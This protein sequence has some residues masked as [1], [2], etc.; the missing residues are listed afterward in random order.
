MTVLSGF[1]GDG[2]MTLLRLLATIEIPN[3]G[4]VWLDGAPASRGGTPWLLNPLTRN[5]VEIPIFQDPLG[6]LDA[7]WP[8]W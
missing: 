1:L 5:G 7:R 6:S 4:E 2:K 3:A 8:I